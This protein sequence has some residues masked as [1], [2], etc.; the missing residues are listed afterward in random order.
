MSNRD[1]EILRE[2]QRMTKLLSVIAMHGMTQRERI[3][4][5]AQVG[6]S[7]KQIAELLSTTSNT[8]SVYLSHLRKRK[9]R[10]AGNRQ[11][12]IEE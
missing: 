8:V 7:P 9:N 11:A 2:L 1:D 3:A 10:Q 4:T 6:F 12:E 5:L